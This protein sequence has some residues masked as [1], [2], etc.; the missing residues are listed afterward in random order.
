MLLNRFLP[1]LL[2][3]MSRL[4]QPSCSLP[5]I[6]LAA[7]EISGAQETVQRALGISI[8]TIHAPS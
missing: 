3:L 2:N 7:P 6:V 5:V 4:A 1:I 8:R